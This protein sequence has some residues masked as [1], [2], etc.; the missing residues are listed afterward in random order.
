MAGS[1]SEGYHSWSQG[2]EFGW[3]NELEIKYFKNIIKMFMEKEKGT[4]R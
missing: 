3:R 4:A 2:S 1:V